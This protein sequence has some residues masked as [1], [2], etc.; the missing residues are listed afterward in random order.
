MLEK[1][2]KIISEAIGQKLTGS[3]TIHFF[4]GNVSTVEQKQSFKI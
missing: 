1:V 3:I 4:Q 2:L